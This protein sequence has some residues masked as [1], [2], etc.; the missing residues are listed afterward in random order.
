M[1]QLDV[2]VVGAGP[3]GLAAGINAASYDLNTLVLEKK[4]P[5]GCAAE[6]PLLEN[7]PG[8][9]EGIAGKDLIDNMV[10]QCEESG[11][12]IQQF[13]S[14][15]ELHFEDGEHVVNT[16]TSSYK[17]KAVILATGRSCK[18][19]GIPGEEEYRGRGVSYCAVC[20]GHFFKEKRVV[21]VG[22]DNRAAEVAIYLSG[23]AS[24]V[25][26]LCPEKTVCAENILLKN[27]KSDR[28]NVL[29]NI[30]LKE[31]QG[32]VNVQSVIIADSD[33]GK[34]IE[35][36]TDGV[37]FQ[38]E[39]TP[40]S[41]IAKNIGINVDDNDYILVDSHGRTNIDGVYAIGDVTTCQIKMVITAV[42]QAA[43][44]AIDAFGYISRLK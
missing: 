1:E 42:S 35:I 5:G 29:E 36:K 39:D 30:V 6:I 2:I 16:D 43:A 4:I 37:F 13:K 40:N 12:D 31:I 27:L 21:V 28:I 23:L 18:L 20:D 24:Y 9:S 33:T 3:A 26:L 7:Y 14:V 44:A 32:D 25:N 17:S 34:T 38:L 19:L 15:V 10:R 11:V 8:Y 22:Y 41:L